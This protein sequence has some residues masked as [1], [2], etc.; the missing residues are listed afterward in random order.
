MGKPLSAEEALNEFPF[1]MVIVTTGRDGETAGM[2]ATWATQVSWRPSYLGVAI[3]HKWR[4]LELILKYREFAVHLVS[5][6]LLEA[7]LKVFGGMSSRKVD[8]FS[9]VR[10]KYGLRVA[11]GSKVNVPV[12]LDAPIVFECLLREYHVIG[13]HYL[14]VCDPVSV[15]RNNE[16][17]PI[18]FHRGK[19]RTLGPPV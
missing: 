17:E 1:P 3:Y 19:S 8:K 15:Y 12:L 7:A 16:D 9:L 10:E 14:V 6:R 18:V 5:G 13:D 11:R 4:T 2:T